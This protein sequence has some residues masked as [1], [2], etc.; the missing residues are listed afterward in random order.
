MDPDYLIL[1]AVVATA[2][3]LPILLLMQQFSIADRQA[4]MHRLAN[5]LQLEYMSGV[6]KSQLGSIA[7]AQLFQMGTGSIWSSI[8]QDRVTN[9]MF[10]QTDQ[11]RL[12]IFDYEYT[13]GSGKHR[14][15]RRQTVVAMMFAGLHLAPCRVYPESC[16]N[17]LAELLG[18]QDIN[19][20]DHPEF[21]RLF[22]VQSHHEAETREMFD[23]PL[24]DFFCQDPELHFE[25]TRTAF[26]L[27]RPRK[28]LDPAEIRTLMASAYQMYQALMDMQERR[29]V[30]PAI[31]MLQAHS[32][33]GNE[34]T[35]Y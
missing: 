26:M 14:H 1:I 25:S 19:F 34:P 29:P 12:Q 3:I 22:V 16:L 23:G 9:F 13:I 5:E 11:A 24:M 28:I 35:T 27:H 21:S 6:P 20:E 2:L 30:N 8:G 31:Q 7:T 10:G 32:V 15:T 4:T 18:D 33:P 17:F